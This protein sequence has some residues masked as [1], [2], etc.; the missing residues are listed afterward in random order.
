MPSFAEL[1]AEAAREEFEREW[2][3]DVLRELN[4]PK[5]FLGMTPSF[6]RKHER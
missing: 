1:E 4:R 3:R 6:G 2:R 5:A